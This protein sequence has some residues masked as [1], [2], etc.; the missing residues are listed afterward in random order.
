MSITL[1]KHKQSVQ[2]IVPTFHKIIAAHFI[3]IPFNIQDK[4]WLGESTF[5]N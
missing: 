1:Y 3:I 2:I 5:N 4:K